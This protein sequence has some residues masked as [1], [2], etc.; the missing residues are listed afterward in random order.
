MSKHTLS[1]RLPKKVQDNLRIVG[2]Q[3]KLARR[4]R[5]IPLRRIA[6]ASSCSELT[7]MRIEK[8]EGS[9]SMAA[10]LRVLYALQLDEDILAIAR[11]DPLG[12]LLQDSEL[13]KQ[14]AVAHENSDFTFD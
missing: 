9:V 8:G 5:K 6:E 11:E 3:I 1:T 2:E 12:R 10:Y 7:V 13:M 4:R 14:K